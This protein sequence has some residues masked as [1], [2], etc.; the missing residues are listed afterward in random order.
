VDERPAILFTAFEP[1]GDEHAACVI[2]E[3]RRLLP[4]AP[5]HGLGGERMAEAGCRIIEQTSGVGRM[6]GDSAW[7]VVDHFKR[8]GRIRAWARRRAI[9]VHVPTDSPAANWSYCRMIKRMY[10]R[11]RPSRP[12][13]RVVHL[14]APQVWAWAQWRVKRLRKWSDLVLCLLPFEPAW[15]RAR[16]VNAR[17]I[18]HPAFDRSLDTD[19]L[20]WEAMDFPAGRPRV[21]LL[22]GSRATE[23]KR[24]WPVLHES[25]VRLSQR[26]PD[27]QAVVGAVSESA[28]RQL[29]RMTPHADQSIHFAHSRT[30]AVLHWA[31]VVLTV[32]GTVTLHVA[33]HGK[34]MAIVYK[35]NPLP[36]YLLGQ[37]LVDTRT[38]T[39]PNLIALGRA[40]PTTDQ[41]VVREFVPF[42]GDVQPIVSELSRL[43]DDRDHRVAQVEALRGVVSK[44]ENHHAGREAA[45]RIAEQYEAAL[46]PG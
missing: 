18:G 22:P 39:L 27:A 45:E 38:F 43:V 30:D 35:S 23:L 5:I 17:F 25:F 34:P 36:W 28:M 2:A 7:Q 40:L 12:A 14:V 41:H 11:P 46:R 31:D 42:W 1:S 29:R 33:R 8:L 21:A 10:R 6:L 24:N 44:F 26:H 13:T 16:Q 20:N 4:E 32:S 15:F 3:L 37:F 9:A 19:K